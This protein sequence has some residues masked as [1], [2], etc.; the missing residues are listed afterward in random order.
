MPTPSTS[1]TTNSPNPTQS[2]TSSLTSLLTSN[3]PAS[4]TYKITFLSSRG[5][6]TA[7][8]NVKSGDSFIVQ[9][10]SPVGNA[11]H[12]WIYTGFSIDGGKEIMGVIYTFSNVQLSIQLLSTG[13][14][15]T[16]LPYFLNMDQQAEADGTIQVQLHTSL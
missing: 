13:K 14:S 3:Q 10:S 7:S 15:N 1:P 11:T 16:T 8:A 5:F 12:R 6:P 9:V 4:S 2:P